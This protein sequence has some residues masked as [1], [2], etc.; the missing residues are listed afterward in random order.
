MA[1][2]SDSGHG[3]HGGG[4]GHSH[5]GLGFYIGI[6]V[7]LAIITGLEIWC[8]MDTKTMNHHGNETLV[9]GLLYFFSIAKFVGVV[10]F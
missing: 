9:R 6:A 8:V 5:A 3:G 2:H 1:E 7:Y 4:E 10:L